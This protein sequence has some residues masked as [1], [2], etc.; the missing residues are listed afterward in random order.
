MPRLT[1]IMNVREFIVVLRRSF[2]ALGLAGLAAASSLSVMPVAAQ[3][4]PQIW[5]YWASGAEAD[6]LAALMGVNATQHPDTPLTS[7]VI[8]GSAAEMRAALQ[9][10]FLGGNPPAV[11]QSTMGQELLSFVQSG[12]LASLDEVWAEVDGD[13]NFPAGVKRVVN[14]DNHVYGIP[15]N[16][17]LISN[18]FYNKKIFA[19]LGLE[20]PKT[21]EE[22]K[23]VATALKDA[24]YQALGN[25]SGPAWTLYGS[26]PFLYAELGQDGYFDLA[27]GEI[28]FTDERVKTALQNYADT[29]A[30][31]YMEN[32][33]GYTWSDTAAQFAEGKVGMYQMG[34]WLSANLTDAGMVA[35][36]DYDVFPAPGFDG[37]VVMQMD[38]L[39]QTTQSNEANGL[40]GQNFLRTAASPEGQIA[41]NLK[42]GSVAPNQAAPAD[43]YGYYSKAAASLVAAAG[44]KAVPNLKNLLPVQLGNEFGNV[45]V[46]YA[47]APSPAALDAML[48]GLEQMRTQL[49]AEG[50]FYRW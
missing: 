19:E 8:S 35:G 10:A 37:A 16:I 22:F 4:G 50:A 47:Q 34:D 42:K 12:R 9:T 15:L 2:C 5:S 17:H 3:E 7:R 38:I 48:A 13:A 31:N 39:A 40:A 23:A 30:A 33:S 49:Q 46:S 6:A 25:A 45:I 11:Y 32:W 43:Q 27:S 14:F 36:E 28:P 41:F 1:Q 44:D 20:V 26:Y 29:Y 21:A 18:V 24:G